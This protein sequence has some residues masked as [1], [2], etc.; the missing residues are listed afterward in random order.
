MFAPLRGRFQRAGAGSGKL[1]TTKLI[2]Q[3]LGY[4]RQYYYK[5][6]KQLEQIAEQKKA[7]KKLIDE[8]RK[9]LPRLGVRKIYYQITPALQQQGLKLGRDK[10]FAWMKEYDLLIKHRRRYVQTTNSKHWLRK[11][12]NQIKGLSV[13]RP[14]QVWVSDITHIKT[15]EGNCFLNLVTDAYSRK[16]MGYSIASNME[17]DTMKKA[18][19]MAL[20]GRHYPGAPLVHHSDRG[21]QYCSRE[22]VQLSNQHNVVISM[23][24]NGDPYENALAERMN[25]T[26][27]EEFGLGRRLPS[28]QQ[29]F[30]LAEQ[31]VYL[32]N[33]FRPHLSLNMQT[34]QTVH[35]QKIPAPEAPGL[36]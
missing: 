3:S 26:L 1:V 6:Q 35:L 20:R 19:E 8:Q 22:Y 17:A 28:R 24:E 14:E 27:K 29:A 4:S 36:S 13:T 34:P 16:I 12:P 18:Y 33:N 7:V 25:R 9:L 32:Y 5:Q 11:Y 2:A 21:L 10:L 23:T 31:A 30:R 15:D